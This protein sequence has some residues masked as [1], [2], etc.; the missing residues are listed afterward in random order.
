MFLLP[1][2]FSPPP[3]PISE[4]QNL[5]LYISLLY[6]LFPSQEHG[7]LCKVTSGPG[8]LNSLKLHPELQMGLDSLRTKRHC[9]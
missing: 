9:S 5:C 1:L 2:N 3:R 8:A 4:E 6:L 7:D